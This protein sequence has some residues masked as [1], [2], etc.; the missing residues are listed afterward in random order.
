MQKGGLL[1]PVT[2]ITVWMITVND[3]QTIL[4][5]TA[6]LPKRRGG[7]K[8]FRDTPTRPTARNPVQTTAYTPLVRADKPLL[9]KGDSL[10]LV[11]K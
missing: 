3:M 9:Q 7:R 11:I 6:V 10:T 5:S 8:A 2:T 4:Q 1:A